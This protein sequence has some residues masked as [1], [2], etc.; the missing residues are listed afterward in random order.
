MVFIVTPKVGNLGMAH[1][2]QIN[3]FVCILYFIREIQGL[4]GIG[5]IV[6]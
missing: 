5:L 4:I 1:I 2:K 6:Y 3:V